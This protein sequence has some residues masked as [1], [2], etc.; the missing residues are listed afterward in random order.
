MAKTQKSR[1]AVFIILPVLRRTTLRLSCINI[2]RLE[3]KVNN[4]GG[5][6]KY[7]SEN[8]LTSRGFLQFWWVV[9]GYISLG[10][11][12]RHVTG[13]KSQIWYGNK[14]LIRHSIWDFESLPWHHRWF[15]GNKYGI[16]HLLGLLIF[17]WICRQFKN[18]LRI[19]ILLL[20]N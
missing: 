15:T 20:S 5:W 14:M 1:S 2:T 12:T 7:F 19:T 10:V 17:L 11:M 4:C 9:S 13:V 8:T 18:N 16:L 3:K 6:A